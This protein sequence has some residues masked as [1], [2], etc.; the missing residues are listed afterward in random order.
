M[1]GVGVVGGGVLAALQPLN[2]NSF[3]THLATGRIILDRGSVPTTDPYTF[4]APGA[5]WVVQSWL[6]SVLYAGAERVAGIDGVRLLVA[7]LAGGLTAIG[8]RLTRPAEG[9]LG[10]LMLG[11]IFVAVGA[12]VWA[13]RPLMVGLIGFALVVLSAEGGLDPRWLVPVGWIWVNSHGSFP[14]GLVYLVVVL[15]GT[16]FDG[17][18][19]HREL[20]CLGW[21]IAGVV[22][23]VV[24]P[25]GHRALTFPVELLQ[26]RDVLVDVVEWQAP[27][28]DDLGQR[29]FLAQLVLAA[30]LL[31]RRPSWRRNL[32]FGVFMAAALLGARNIAVASIAL[33][34]AMAIGLVEVGSLGADTRPRRA[35]ALLAVFTAA[36][37]LL[38]AARLQQP[39]LRLSAYPLDVLAFLEEE[40]IDT[41]A[42]RMAGPELVGNLIAYA[43]GPEG[44]VFYDD[45]FEMFPE[46][47]SAA[48]SAI[49]DPVPEMFDQLQSYDIDLVVVRR[50][51]PTAVVL[52]R[53]ADWRVLYAGERW[54]LTCR[55]GAD[56]A[57]A[58]PC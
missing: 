49:A 43:Y 40:E 29:A 42:V 53:D 31:A 57:G 51:H 19:V 12:G 10:R 27:S 41:R 8:W 45:R 1:L 21:A 2:D 3:L 32:V 38:V 33:L 54:I 56:L 35:R 24:G 17:R 28:F 15:V 34:P 14:L 36:V 20:R 47:V 58:A 5:D 37:A 52:T 23:G 44:R 6:V 46:A 55:R 48:H 26:R 13:E 7:V 11:A 18:D 4:T 50:E 25:L 30:L 9:V 16:R 22:S 39:A